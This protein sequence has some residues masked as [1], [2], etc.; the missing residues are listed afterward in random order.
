M[1]TSTYIVGIK[2]TS[3]LFLSGRANHAIRHARLSLFPILWSKLFS[4]SLYHALLPSRDKRQK[5]S[6][7][8]DQQSGKNEEGWINLLLAWPLM[9]GDQIISQS[10]GFVVVWYLVLPGSRSRRALFRDKIQSQVPE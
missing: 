10:D 2:K 8:L 6:V 9:Y 3:A 4:I 7:F 5:S 1:C